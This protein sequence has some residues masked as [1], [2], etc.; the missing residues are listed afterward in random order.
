MSC[1]PHSARGA[2]ARTA[3]VQFVQAI[4]HRAIL[5]AARVHDREHA[6][7]HAAR[8]CLDLRAA[9]CKRMCVYA[10]AHD[11]FTPIGQR[12]TLI[13]DFHRASDKIEN[14]GRDLN[15]IYPHI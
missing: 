9:L 3:D 12:D 4:V 6:A 1:T 11:V 5:V 10:L 2:H 8:E 7:L 13:L 14:D 15:S